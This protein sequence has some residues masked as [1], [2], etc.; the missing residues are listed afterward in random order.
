MPTAAKLVAAAIF[1]LVAFI[2]ADQYAPLIP[3]GR[4]AGPLREVTA[5]IGVICGWT[6]MGSFLRRSHSAVE[7]MGTGLRVSVTIA[8][9]S[10][11]LFSIWDV[12][13]RA[14]DGR[15]KH[16]MDSLLDVFGR[17]LVLGTPIFSPGV[18]G[19]LALGGL[20]GGALAHAASTRWK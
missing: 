7:A 11:I 5:I 1:A 17:A 16:P 15:Y 9:V 3:D 13:M 2:A 10:L 20:A 8:F 14:I 19:V 12:L 18:L 4:P 6:I